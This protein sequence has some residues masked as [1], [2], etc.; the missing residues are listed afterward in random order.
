MGQLLTSL[1]IVGQA[2][3]QVFNVFVGQVFNLPSPTFVLRVG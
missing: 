3:G 1:M 2:R